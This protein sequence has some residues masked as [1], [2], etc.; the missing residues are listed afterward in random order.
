M[1]ELSMI[2]V[3]SVSGGCGPGM[4]DG[5]FEVFVLMSALAGATLFA[6]GVGLGYV[7]RK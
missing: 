1:K 5:L 6:L 7:V 4:L 3:Q 2:E